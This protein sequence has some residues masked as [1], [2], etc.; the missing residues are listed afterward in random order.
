MQVSSCL[1]A[2]EV[3][4]PKRR[5]G[6][7]AA[8][9]TS[10][11][12][13]VSLGGRLANPSAGYAKIESSLLVRAPLGPPIVPVIIVDALGIAEAAADLRL[14]QTDQ[15]RDGSIGCGSGPLTGLGC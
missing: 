1:V 11:A 13:H 5:T 15:S 12:G 7:A 6:R 3:G 10:F 2:L 4:I 9:E 14:A 8:S